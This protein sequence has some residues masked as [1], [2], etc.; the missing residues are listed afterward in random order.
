MWLTSIK[1]M[2]VFESSGHRN[3]SPFGNAWLCSFVVLCKVDV[4]A[5][6]CQKL[7]SEQRS[8]RN[9]CQSRGLSE[10]DVRA[11]VCQKLMS[12]QGLVRNWLYDRWF[13]MSSSSPH[14]HRVL[15]VGSRNPHFFSADFVRA[16][17]LQSR[18]RLFPCLPSGDGSWGQRLGRLDVCIRE[19]G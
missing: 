1:C 5:G 7:M 18:L 11:G 16:T 4:R 10:T 15:A 12:E 2:N 6:V 14:S 17:A 9:W 3:V 8:V 19:F 13:V